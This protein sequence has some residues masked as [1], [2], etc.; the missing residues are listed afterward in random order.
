LQ[1]LPSRQNA[2][3]ARIL[4]D[5]F[6]PLRSCFV[7][8]PGS[9]LVSSD[10]KS[11]E[12]VA[13]GNLANCSK[14]LEDAKGDLHS[15][16]AVTAMGAPEWDGYKANIPP[17]D[18]WVK[19][20]KNLRIARK[21]VNF[22]IPYQRGAKAISREIETATKGAMKCSSHQAQE[23]IDGFYSDYPEV[24]GYVELCKELVLEPG[25][26]TNA[27]GRTRRF[28]AGTRDDES[29]VAAMQRQGV[30]FPIQGTVAD[31]LNLAC[32]NLY[33][34]RAL[35]PGRAHYRILLAVHD[36]VILECPGAELGVVMDEVLPQCMCRG[37][38]IPSWCPPGWAPTKPFNLEIEIGVGVRWD[39]SASREELVAAGVAMDVVE[40]ISG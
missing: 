14:L 22:G 2:E 32:C 24:L 29:L 31:A 33:A 40:R 9:V 13:L 30:N 17:P 36:A 21:T 34:W 1:N 11:A 26:L 6:L 39:E 28:Y 23:M 19:K 25:Y 3:I 27:F 5:D 37:V 10:Y 20:Y 4:G 8:R 16:G 15:R 38:T 18:E 12:I 35:N 7:S